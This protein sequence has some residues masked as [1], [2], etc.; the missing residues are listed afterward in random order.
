[1]TLAWNTSHSIERPQRYPAERRN[2]FDSPASLAVVFAVYSTCLMSQRLASTLETTPG[3]CPHF[4]SCVTWE[5]H[6]YLLNTIARLFP[7][8]IRSWILA[9][10]QENME[11]K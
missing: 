8:V 7:E 1:M 4:T 2:A 10:R 3:S 11:D 9:R 5:T 6:C